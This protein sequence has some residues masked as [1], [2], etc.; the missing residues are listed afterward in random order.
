LNVKHQVWLES[1]Q[2]ENV[3]IVTR[4]WTPHAQAVLAQALFSCL[5]NSN[6]EI[7]LEAL[8]CPFA[9]SVHGTCLRRVGVY[10]SVLSMTQGERISDCYIIHCN[11]C[12]K[13]S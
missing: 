2:L 7:V 3:S 13:A 12:T 10:Y 6:T 11:F 1:S 5:K 4:A 9:M 8:S